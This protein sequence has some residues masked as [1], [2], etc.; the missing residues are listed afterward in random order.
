M[1]KQFYLT[2]RYD[3]NWHDQLSL[4]GPESHVNEDGLYIPKAQMI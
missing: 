4:R 2:Y 3:P 1:F